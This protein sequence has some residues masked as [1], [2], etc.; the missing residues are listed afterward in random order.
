MFGRGGGEEELV[1]RRSWS[2]GGD[3]E[4]ELVVKRR[5][6]WWLGGDW[7]EELVVKRRRSR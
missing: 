7:E 1:V 3:W 4:E 5:R 2:L 6:S